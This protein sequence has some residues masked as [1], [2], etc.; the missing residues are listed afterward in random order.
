MAALAEA[1]ICGSVKQVV[2]LVL[3]PLEVRILST[4]MPCMLAGTLIMTFGL[5][6]R[7][8]S[9]SVTIWSTSVNRRGSSWPEIQP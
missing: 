5:M 4:S 9:A 6:A 2:V 1:M 7:S 8:S 3:M